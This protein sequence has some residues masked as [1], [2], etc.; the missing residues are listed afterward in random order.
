MAVNAI[1]CRK[2]R[3]IIYNRLL[4]YIVCFSF[5]PPKNEKSFPISWGVAFCF[6]KKKGKVLLYGHEYKND[7]AVGYKAV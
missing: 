4:E 2:K 6:G 5:I 7:E 1:V 3:C